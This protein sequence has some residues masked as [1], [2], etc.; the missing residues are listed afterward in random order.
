MEGINMNFNP[1][2]HLSNRAKKLWSEIVPR[3]AESPERLTLFQTALEALDRADE[4]A[5]IIKKEGMT[6]TTVTTGTVHSHPAVKIEREARQVF[7]KCWRHLD[8][9]WNE[10]TDGGGHSFEAFI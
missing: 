1:P 9:Q 6:I 3:R 5:S 10:A 2:S 4:A 8:L 7:I